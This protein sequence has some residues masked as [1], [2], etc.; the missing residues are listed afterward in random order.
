MLEIRAAKNSSEGSAQYLAYCLMIEK[1]TS[2]DKQGTET[3][4]I[5]MDTIYVPIR[6]L[7]LSFDTHVV[8]ADVPIL[9][10]IDNMDLV[11]VYLGILEEKIVHP[12]SNITTR[13]EQK[14]RHPFLP[15]SQSFSC[16]SRLWN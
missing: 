6:R 16:F 4:N 1:Q 5:D 8:K 10:C 12:T 11:A 7:R 15:S 9:V 3:V 13:I 14:R 2:G